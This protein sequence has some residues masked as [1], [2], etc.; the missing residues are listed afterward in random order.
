MAERIANGSMEGGPPPDPLRTP[1]NPLVMMHEDHL[2]ER[3]ILTLLDRI[4]DGGVARVEELDDALDFLSV[5]LPR[6]LHK[7]PPVQY[8]D[9]GKKA[10]RN[11]ARNP[12]SRIR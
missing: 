3:E 2:H 7:R 12:D 6:H 5:T 10:S 1:D 11:R 9:L 4:A 8:T